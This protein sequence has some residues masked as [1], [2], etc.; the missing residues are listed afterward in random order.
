MNTQIPIFLFLLILKDL[1]ILLV[2]KVICLSTPDKLLTICLS[3]SCPRFLS[4]LEKTSRRS[5]HLYQIV[6]FLKRW[7]SIKSRAFACVWRMR[8]ILIRYWFCPFTSQGPEFR[9]FLLT[10]LINAENACYK[11][12]KFAKLEVSKNNTACFYATAGITK[13]MLS[14]Y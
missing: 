1:L 4:R 10:K 2:H 14:L 8:I 5:A 9:E 12:D 13:Q 3:D 7:S 6:P 11:S